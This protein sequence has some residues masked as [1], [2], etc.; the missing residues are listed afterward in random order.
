MG[1]KMNH[2][3]LTPSRRDEIKRLLAADPARVDETAGIRIFGPLS[4]DL[5]HF[6]V[7]LTAKENNSI[8]PEAIAFPL[9][10]DLGN[11]FIG[12]ASEHLS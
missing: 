5:S 3:M 6:V 9:P 10:E 11:G 7:V 12:F 1:D 4:G 8:L 2:M